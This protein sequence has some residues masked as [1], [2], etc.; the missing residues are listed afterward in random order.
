[1]QTTNDKRLSERQRLALVSLLADDDATVY[2]AVRST[3]LSYGAEAEEWL[4]TELLSGNPTL[5]RRAREIV[6]YRSRE[7]SHL[8]FVT[9]CSRQGEHLDLEEAS[10]LLARTRFPEINPVAYSALLDLWGDQLQARLDRSK[11]DESRLAAFNEFF[12][13]ILAFRGQDGFGSKP[14]S[15]YINRILDKRS[16]NPIGLCAVY[17]SIARRTQMPIT[18]IG[19]PGHFLCRYQTAQMETY[20]DCFRPGML[21]SKAD[22]T[23]YLLRTG[24]ML[25]RQSLAPVSSRNMLIRMCNNLVITYGHLEDTKEAN[26]VQDY[27]ATLVR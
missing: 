21:L 27:V 13:D 4:Q 5:R 18:G 14:E 11:S 12:F 6:E 19:L 25:S 17:L 10:L 24:Q 23:E 2:R 26:R 20:I 7:R 8:Q 15:C 3:L 1:M 9:Y 22:C 16:G